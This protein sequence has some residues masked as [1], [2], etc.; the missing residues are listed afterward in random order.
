MQSG[1]HLPKQSFTGSTHSSMRHEAGL[2]H[3]ALHPR[4][5]SPKTTWRPSN[6]GVETV[7][8]KNLHRE[9]SIITSM[10]FAHVCLQYMVVLVLIIEAKSTAAAPR[11][12]ISSM[13]HSAWPRQTSTWSMAADAV[14]KVQMGTCAGLNPC[15]LE[16]ILIHSSE[17]QTLWHHWSSSSSYERAVGEHQAFSHRIPG[18]A[19]TNCLN[20]GMAVWQAPA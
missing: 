10:T 8:M 3:C 18:A 20:S 4:R 11:C 1:V 12:H 9:E 13:R 19:V 17:L 5:T 15:S 14:S 7:Q 6:Q 16:H 2:P